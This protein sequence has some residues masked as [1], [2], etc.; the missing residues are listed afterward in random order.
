MAFFHGV[1]FIRADVWCLCVQYALA[2]YQCFVYANLIF[3]SKQYQVIENTIIQKSTRKKNKKPYIFLIT[4]NLFCLSVQ[5][6][7]C[8]WLARFQNGGR[9]R[10]LIWGDPEL[11]PRAT[12]RRGPSSLYLPTNPFVPLWFYGVPGASPGLRMHPSGLGQS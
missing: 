6:L 4:L 3:V 9:D 8:Y 12:L 2:F 10:G 7:M 11:N 5:L 1:G